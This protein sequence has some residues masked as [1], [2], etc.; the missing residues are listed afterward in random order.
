ME[1]KDIE[2]QARP[3]KHFTVTLNISDLRCQ[4]C[5]E[6]V[7]ASLSRLSGVTDAKVSLTEKKAYVSCQAAPIN[8]DDLLTVLEKQGY[9]AHEMK[10]KDKKSPTNYFGRILTRFSIP[11]PYL[12]G[13]IA[14]F[15][16]VGIYLG[17]NT[18]T[19]DWYSAR[20]QFNEYRWWI[21]ALAFGLGVQ[22]TLF[23]HLRAQLKKHRMRMAKSSMVAS[24]G[25]STAAMMACCSHYLATVVPAL[26]LPFLSAAAVTKLEQYQPY[27]FLAGILSCIVG[28]ALMLR[29]IKNNGMTPTGTIWRFFTVGL[30]R[31][32]NTGGTGIDNVKVF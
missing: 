3:D 20:V 17:M 11:R 18:L 8:T 24:G 19:A 22:V 9:R 4:S 29:I 12:F 13:T 2:H 7:E 32:L 28:I 25:V 23:S 15:A 30:G 16:I 10:A 6:R 5:V 31:L 21:V 1:Y 26:S 27:L 14:S